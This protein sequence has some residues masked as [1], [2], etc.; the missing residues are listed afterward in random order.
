MPYVYPSTESL[1]AIASEK[2]PALTLNDPLFGFFPIEEEDTAHVTWEQGDNV[3]GLQ[4]ARGMG[5][6]PSRVKRVG[7]KKYTMEPGIYG[8]FI[9]LDEI[10][11]TDARMIGET[12]NADLTKQ[13]LRISDQ[14]QARFVDRVRYIGW[15]ACQGTLSV[16]GQD[17]SIMHSDTY[18]VQ[19]ASASVSWAT[20]ATAVPIKDFRTWSLLSAGKGC[21]FGAGAK[22]Y[23]N[24]VTANKLL[25][26]ANA[27]DLFGK[28][29]TGSSTI[30]SMAE[31]NKILLDADLPEIVVY[32]EGYIATGGSFARFI[33]DDKVIIIGKRNDGSRIGAYKMT[34]N[35]NNEGAKPGQYVKVVVDEKA[36]PIEAVVHNGHNGGPAIEFPGSIIFASV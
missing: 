27:A 24:R 36:V 9:P 14:L 3:T 30:S 10:D 8:E 32:D 15:T 26:N 4:Q 6:K 35:A 12:G 34:R 22:A 21:S 28:R 16:L 1:K 25:N 18:P 20:S 19:T 13:V 2:M 7:Q 23:M 17:G 11:L 33:P 5:G 29:T 31:V